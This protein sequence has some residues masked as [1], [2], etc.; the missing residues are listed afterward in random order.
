[1]Q[2][3]GRTPTRNPPGARPSARAGRAWLATAAV[4]L[5]AALWWRHEAALGTALMQ[6]YP[7]A[8][9]GD[10]ALAGWALAAAWRS[11]SA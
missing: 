11:P 6:A 4:L 2:P 3:S 1:M 5:T 8:I 9:P 10:P 7:D